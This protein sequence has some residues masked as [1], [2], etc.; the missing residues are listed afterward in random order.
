MRQ[1]HGAESFKRIREHV[2]IVVLDPG[3]SGEFPAIL[4]DTYAERGRKPPTAPEQA[5]HQRSLQACRF[6]GKQAVG[7]LNGPLND[8][9]GYV[10][11]PRGS[12][13]ARGDVGEHLFERAP[14][15]REL[16]SQGQGDRLDQGTWMA[17]QSRQDDLA[18]IDADAR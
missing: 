1:R 18:S 16:H 12:W 6:E 17:T 14:P 8:P 2:P 7:D 4:P 13:A 11:S 5:Q 3:V 9:G 15:E 10:T